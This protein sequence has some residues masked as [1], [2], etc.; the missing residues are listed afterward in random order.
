MHRVNQEIAGRLEEA[1]HLLGDQGADPY[2]ISAYVRAAASVRS[3]REPID[4][5]FRE[6]G[7]EGLQGIPR[8]GETIA[9]AIRELL[10]YGRLRCLIGCAARRM[11]SLY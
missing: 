7:L 2:R 8:V 11:R 9:R 5:V 1:A 3:W 10:T 4:T 6:R